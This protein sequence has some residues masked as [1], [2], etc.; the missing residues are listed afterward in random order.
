LILKSLEEARGGRQLGS[1][2]MPSAE[3][4]TPSRGRRLGKRALQLAAALVVVAVAAGTL[5]GALLFLIRQDMA[6]EEIALMERDLASAAELA[7]PGR[8]WAFRAASVL[9]LRRPVAEMTWRL[10]RREPWA[11]QGADPLAKAPAPS[12]KKN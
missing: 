6:P 11:S 9:G 4:E 2:S 8:G 5:R 3:A 12:P 1:Q 10:K 7:T